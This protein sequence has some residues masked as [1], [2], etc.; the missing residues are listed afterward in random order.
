MAPGPGSGRKEQGVRL[1]RD[2]KAKGSPKSLGP[3]SG[4][5]QCRGPSCRADSLLERMGPLALLVD[6]LPNDTQGLLSSPP[7]HSPLSLVSEHILSLQCV[8]S[9]PFKK[10]KAYL[11]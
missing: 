6:F 7:S 1:N 9:E 10:Q 4:H 5:R 11:K 8:Q 2:Y 3:E